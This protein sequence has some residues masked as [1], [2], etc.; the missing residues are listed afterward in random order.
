MRH[1]DFQFGLGT[2]FNTNTAFDTNQ[3]GHSSPFQLDFFPN[4]C[5]HRLPFKFDHVVI[6]HIQQIESL[7][8]SSGTNCDLL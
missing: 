1:R 4:V 6:S 5:A 7:S 3:I 8:G 2:G